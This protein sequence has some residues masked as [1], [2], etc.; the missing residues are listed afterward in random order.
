MIKTINSFYIIIFELLILFV[1]SGYG[2]MSPGI[3][4]CYAAYNFTVE[5]EEKLGRKFKNELQ[6]HLELIQDPSIQRYID[7]IGNKIISQ[8]EYKPFDF[9]FYIYDASDPNAFAIPAGYIYISTGLITLAENESEIAG[10]LSHEI[11]HVTERHIAEKIEKDKMINLGTLIAILAGMFLGGSD[12]AASAVGAFSIA[13]AQTLSLKYTRE[14][15]EEADRLGLDYLIKAGYNGKAM[16][17][18][19][20]KI[21]RY[22]VQAFQTP[23]YLL[24][25]PEIENRT[26]YLDIMLNRFPQQEEYKDRVDNFQRIKARVIA[27]CWA[28]QN[29]MDYFK[30]MLK[31][32]PRR[33]D[34][35]YGLALTNQR[36]KNYNE[37]INWLNLVL[38]INPEDSEVLRD[39]GVCFFFIEKPDDAIVFLQ[40]AVAKNEKDKN[41]FFYLGLSHQENGN[42][43]EAI[44]AYVI[45]RNLDKGFTHVYYNLGVAY[46]H[47]EDLAES[48]R[49]FGIFFKLKGKKDSALF[50]FKKALNYYKEGAEKRKEVLKEL[51]EIKSE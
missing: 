25:H 20:K 16:I 19:L 10:V 12:K 28:P 29:A 4:S 15:E 30:S 43:K 48:H 47:I 26:D 18:F 36:L 32:N 9:N 40:R 13:T 14:N 46:G 23:P 34:L 44:E 49:N 7:G 51:E 42:Y 1:L 50:H 17:T 35:I 24:T 2:V 3:E 39:I 11:A 33:F 22:H 21:R 27:S 31:S 45:V 6:K 38:K 5:Q 37:A 41:A 8:L